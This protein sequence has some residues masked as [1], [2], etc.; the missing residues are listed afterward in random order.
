MC[1]L[2]ES[3]KPCMKQSHLKQNKKP[4]NINLVK[5]LKSTTNKKKKQDAVDYVKFNNGNAIGKIQSVGN[6]TGKTTHFHKK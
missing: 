3:T 2:M 6:A 5:L 4:T 1:L